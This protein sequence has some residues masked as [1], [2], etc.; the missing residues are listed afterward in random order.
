MDWFPPA[1]ETARLQ[2]T[3]Y[4]AIRSHGTRRE[5]DE[6]SSRLPLFPSWS[7]VET[8]STTSARVCNRCCHR[9]RRTADRADRCRRHVDRR[10]TRNPS[11]LAENNAALRVIDNPGR[12]VST[13]LNRAIAAARGGI[14]IRA[15]AHTG[16]APD[17]I[18]QC[19]SVLSDSGA[20]NVGGPWVA[21]P[22]G[23]V[24]SAIAAVFHS[25][26]GSGGARGHDPHY[27][28]PVDTVYLGCWRRDI[29]I[30]SGALMKNSCA[31]RMM[32]SICDSHAREEGFGSLLGSGA[33]PSARLMP[34]A[35][36]AVYAIRILEG[37]RHPEA[38]FARIMATSVPAL[39][40]FTIL[41]LSPRL[42]CRSAAVSGAA[43]VSG[44]YLACALTA[45]DRRR[46]GPGRSSSRFCRGCSFAFT[47]GTGT[48][49]CGGSLISSSGA[50][51]RPRD[52]RHDQANRRP[53]RRFRSGPASDVTM[54]SSVAQEMRKGSVDYGQ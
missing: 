17:Y 28:G 1:G 20:D 26:F 21:A 14:I 19:V 23:Y 37:P 22:R 51:F 9:N 47:S 2:S 4:L 52:V 12:I 42:Q 35:V 34:A 49:F 40:V 11:P 46:F 8:K 16:Y 53:D 27:E 7:H 31:I 54:R 13:G 45:V 44:L 10:H 30:A 33:G 32:N 24:G 36:S 5:R 29:S 50:V 41:V 38:P 43:S 48:A 39:F 6:L 25:K 3:H 18:R 15:D